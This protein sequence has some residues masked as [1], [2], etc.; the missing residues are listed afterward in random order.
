MFP[1][2]FG[3]MFGVDKEADAIKITDRWSQY[4]RKRGETLTKDGSDLKLGWKRHPQA[5]TTK[6]MPLQ[7]ERFN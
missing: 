3:M 4:L 7:A 6:P 1:S 5:G 2:S